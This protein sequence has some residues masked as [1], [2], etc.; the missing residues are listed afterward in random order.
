M[1]SADEGLRAYSL[2]GGK[3]ERRGFLSVMIFGVL[4]TPASTYTYYIYKT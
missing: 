4:C 3:E 2:T 1:S